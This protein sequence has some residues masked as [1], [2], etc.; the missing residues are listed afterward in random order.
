M[1]RRLLIIF[2]FIGNFWHGA[3]GQTPEKLSAGEIQLALKKLNVV[4]SAL[5]LAAHPDDENQMVIGYLSQE[6]LMN[7][8]YLALTRGDGGQNLVGP[9][10]RELLGVMRTE[11]LIQARKVDGSHQFFTRAIDFGYSKT[12]DE[13]LSLWNKD[14]ILSDVVWVIRKFRP[15]V[16]ITR[17]PPD[18]RAG[19]GHHSTSAVLAAEAFNLA[20]DS[21]SYPQ[22]LQYVKPWQPTRLMLNDTE[23]FTKDIAA[24]SK[25]NDSIL[26]VN[27]GQYNPLLGKSVNEI[28]AESRSKHQSQGFGSTGSRGQN[29]EYF[30]LVKGSMPKKS[31]FDDIDTTWN[32]V[33]GGEAFGQL[34]QQAYEN[35]QP[36][37]PSAIVPMLMQ[38]SEALKDIKDDYWQRVKREELN[39]VIAACMG[40]YLETRTGTNVLGRRRGG[41]ET[42][43]GIEEYAAAPGDT[44]TLNV[45]VIN[46]S[47]VA[48]K[49]NKVTFTSIARDTT[50][51]L[52]LPDNVDSM[53]QLK[54]VIPQD[55]EYSGPYWL[56]KPN[57]GFTFTVDDQQLI[58]LDETQ[59]V[60]EAHYAM[61]VDGKPIEFV[62]PLIYKS[63][64]PRS[65]E[66]YQPFVITPPVFVNIPEKVTV[67][68]SEDAKPLTV[69]VQ[70]GTANVRGKLSLDMPDGWQSDPKSYDYDLPMKG[71]DAS[72]SFALTP[73]KGQSTGQVTAVATLDGKTYDQ[74]LVVIDYPHIPTQTLFPKAEARLVKLNIEKRGNTIGYIMGAGDEVPEA[75]K[76]IGY[77]V[78]L[79][80]SNDLRPAYLEKMDAIMVGIRAYNTQEWL[81]YKNSALLQYVNNGGTLI[82]QYNTNHSLVT[83]N[84][85]P[86]PLE[87]SKDRVTD[88]TSTVKLLKPSQPLLNTPNKITKDDFKGWVQE[89]GL[90]FPNKWDDHYQPVLAM[91]DKGEKPLK[92]SLLIAP[93]GKG[94]YI[95]T[96][97]SLF[98][99][100]PAGV[101]GA[102]RLLTNMLS[103]GKQPDKRQ[104][105]NKGKDTKKIE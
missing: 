65:G 37:N 3:K 42:V 6:L 72:F 47:D 55:I 2:L 71:Q 1:L 15:D 43:P 98:R 40:L 101:P 93:Y 91:H 4:G 100:L 52:T 10:I 60:I 25:K 49:L 48:V 58:G 77:K 79:L 5:Y 17:F 78:I 46:R 51:N 26:S 66:T 9:E 84:F 21:N 57:D 20:G 63:N 92:G 54:A 19:H 99:E 96:G 32:R 34:V 30:R 81:R 82:V 41:E 14:K 61:T 83:K 80:Q 33:E 88:E 70:A 8:G 89:R 23:W 39:H 75:L 69:Q 50:V 7:T 36:E 104:S 97:L 64:D 94:Y 103:V 13:T 38:A 90:Y 22:Q 45:E 18:D 44:I 28:A 86:Y 105:D 62:N 24:E 16:I 87:L 95:Y 68:A 11:E 76:Q 31:L 53:V 102:F 85:A 56:K 29:M 73:P 74:S 27:V 59:P 35:F 12:T 67:Y